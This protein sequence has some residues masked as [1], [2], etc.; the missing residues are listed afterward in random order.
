MM[1]HHSEKKQHF[2]GKFPKSRT[3]NDVVTE[4]PP[5]LNAKQTLAKRDVYLTAPLNV[6]SVE[7]LPMER[8]YKQAQEGK[9]KVGQPMRVVYGSQSYK[10]KIFNCE[11]SR[12]VGDCAYK[13]CGV[14]R[15]I[16]VVPP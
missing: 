8:K 11:E 10:Q 3:K 12:E 7:S 13:N 1:N 6:G 4:W 9:I 2:E 5:R 16:S 14:R 15:K